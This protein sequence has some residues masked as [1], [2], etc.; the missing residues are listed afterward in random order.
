MFDEVLDA[1]D[2]LARSL[3]VAARLAAFAPEVYARAK[4]DLRAP[5]L[6]LMRAGA[7]DDPLLGGGVD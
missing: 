4:R 6:A 3:H 5:T 2:V 1:D 7:D